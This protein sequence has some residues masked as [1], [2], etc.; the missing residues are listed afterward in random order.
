M[1]RS[2]GSGPSTHLAAKFNPGC[3]LLMSPYT[4]IK[5]VAS[6]KVGFLSHLLAQQFDNLSK[7]H[8]VTCPCFILHG[9]RDFLIPI[10]HAYALKD[11]CF[12]PCT[13]MAPV[14]MTHNRYDIYEDLIKPMHNFIQNEDLLDKVDRYDQEDSLLDTDSNS[15]S[16]HNEPIV[17]NKPSRLML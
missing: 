5:Q 12:G 11:R 3:L 6:G 17:A 16:Y 13:F 7:M 14:C 1:G 15:G 9:Q 10:E 4:S 8:R 2:L